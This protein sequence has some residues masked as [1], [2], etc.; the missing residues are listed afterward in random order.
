MLKPHMLPLSQISADEF[1]GRPAVGVHCS[2]EPFLWVYG[3]FQRAPIGSELWLAGPLVR[4]SLT[5]KLDEL[6]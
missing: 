2:R 6:E 3:L 1:V 4:A 5:E